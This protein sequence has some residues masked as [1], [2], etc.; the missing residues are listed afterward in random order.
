MAR[1]IG[2]V[3]AILIGA[4]AGLLYGWVINPVQYVDTTPDSLRVDYRTDYVLMVAEAFQG[5]GDVGL[6]VRRLALLGGEPSEKIVQDAILSGTK[7]GYEKADLDRL[8]ALGRAL[9]AWN[10]VLEAPAP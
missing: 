8:R 1:W 2:F 6:A 10:P 9:Q 3:F 5:D 4:A 7:L